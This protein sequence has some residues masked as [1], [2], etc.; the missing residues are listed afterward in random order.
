MGK[1][2]I[3]AG[4]GHGGLAVAALL[5]KRGLDVTVYER[6][7]EGT[8]GHDWADVFA[9]SALEAA[10]LPFPAEDKYTYKGNMTFYSPDMST[11]LR[12]HVPD[13]QL[14]IKMERSDIYAMLIENALDGGVSIT[15]GCT[16]ESPLLNGG[17]VTGIR[18]SQGDFYGDLVI[19]AAGINSPVRTKLPR[20]CGIDKTVKKNER[21]Y[22]YR[23][24]YDAPADMP[25][26]L[27]NVYLLPEGKPGLGWVSAENEHT[28]VFIGRFLPIGPEE[29]QRS[30]EYFRRGVLNFG[31]EP[32]RGGS[33]VQIPVRHPLPVMVCDGYA[34]IGDSAFMTMPI[35][36]TGL[37][38]CFAAAA[39]LADTVL[40]D[41][42]GDYSAENL[43]PYQCAYYKKMGDGYAVLACLTSLLATMRP[44]ELD[45]LFEKGVLTASDFTIG[46]DSASLG[47]IFK[48]SPADVL[49]KLSIFGNRALLKKV[50]DMIVQAGRVMACT[51]GMP[52]EWSKKKV[53]A[54]AAEYKKL[55]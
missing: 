24:F 3:V 5:A 38:N 23:A 15:Y 30:V 32:R 44:E 40:L 1:K 54:W 2:V 50:R 36:G 53:Q 16:I 22:V 12:Q 41:L 14:E 39:M 6:K 10:E 11:P 33:F 27:Y 19:D 28:D 8:L 46:A 25:E 29:A 17:R 18:T 48:M 43:W 20:M 13:D 51:A 55:F 9:P 31:N 37:A 26:D 34:A 21:L 49:A 7:K 45:Y 4:A 42:D 47:A 35:A 52:R